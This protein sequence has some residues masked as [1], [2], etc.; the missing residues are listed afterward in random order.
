MYFFCHITQDNLGDDIYLM[1]FTSLAH[2]QGEEILQD[3]YPKGQKSW[4]S[5]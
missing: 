4:V 1:T 5:S 2:T 3:V